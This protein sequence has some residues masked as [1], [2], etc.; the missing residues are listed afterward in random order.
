MKKSTLPLSGSQT[1]NLIFDSPSGFREEVVR[2]VKD[3]KSV[4][5]FPKIPKWGSLITVNNYKV[6]N[7]L[8]ENFLTTLPV[9]N[10]RIGRLCYHLLYIL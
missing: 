10:M 9:Y 6:L 8:E 3:I 1:Y 7:L 5:I 4:C 2:K